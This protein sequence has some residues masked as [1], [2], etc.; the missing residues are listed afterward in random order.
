MNTVTT[1]GKI[2]LSKGKS[3]SVLLIEQL[4]KLSLKS[5]VVYS[6]RKK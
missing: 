6:S 2:V 1:I 4:E 5:L 3:R